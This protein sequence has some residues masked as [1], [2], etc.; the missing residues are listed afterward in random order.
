MP[1]WVRPF[2]LGLLSG[3]LLSV[4]LFLIPYG[5]AVLVLTGLVGVTL[6][7]LFWLCL[8]LP[9]VRYLAADR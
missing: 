8:L 1:R 2:A 3:A 9:L 6:G 4:P 5:V 7:A